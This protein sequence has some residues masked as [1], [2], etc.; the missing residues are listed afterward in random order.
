MSVAFIPRAHLIHRHL[1]NADTFACLFGIRINW[2]PLLV[3]IDN[4]MDNGGGQG[5][6][7]QHPEEEGEGGLWE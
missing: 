6:R 3:V 1:D 7:A 5:K 2:I 4:K